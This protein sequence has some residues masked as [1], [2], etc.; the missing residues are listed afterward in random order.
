[1]G[2]AISRT[3]PSIDTS[4]RFARAPSIDVFC[5]GSAKATIAGMQQAVN[6]QKHKI[7]FMRPPFVKGSAHPKRALHESQGVT[8]AMRSADDYLADRPIGRR[9]DWCRIRRPTGCRPCGERAGG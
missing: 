3:K 4:A 7:R 8:E 6:T 5:R 1:M 2:H 9:A